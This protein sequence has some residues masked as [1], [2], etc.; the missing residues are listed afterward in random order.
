MGPGD[1]LFFAG[2]TIHGSYPN[3]TQDRWRRSFICHYVG[4]HAQRFTPPQ[5][6]H[7]SHVKR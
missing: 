1:A 6:R 5:G 7:M 4:E 3:L 2:K